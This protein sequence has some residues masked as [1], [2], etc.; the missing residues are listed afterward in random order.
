MTTGEPRKGF[1]VTGTDTGMGKTVF[2]AGL[3]RALGATY[4]KPIQA[5]LD[6]ETDSEAVARLGVDASRIHPERYRLSMPA[7]PHVAAAAEGVPISPGEL[8]LPEGAEPLVIETAG[9]VMVPIAPGL[10]QIDLFG[11]WGL[12]VILC[13]RTTLGTINHTLLALEALRGWGIAVQGVAFIGDAAQQSEEAVAEFGAAR[14]LGRLP[15][16]D[17][18]TAETLA[19][20]FAQAFDIKVWS[21]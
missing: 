16:L 11:I 3:T 15:W 9:G 8:A 21:S 20:A 4:W 7:S 19:H 14:R 17:P 12:P 10:L 6:G 2:A 1:I 13:A 18:L 5:G